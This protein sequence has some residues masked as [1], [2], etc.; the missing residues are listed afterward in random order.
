MAKIGKDV[1]RVEY[2]VDDCT[3]LLCEYFVH[4]YARRTPLSLGTSEGGPDTCS[5]GISPQQIE[6]PACGSP[7]PWFDSNSEVE[8][9]ELLR[10][11]HELYSFAHSLLEECS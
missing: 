1:V 5:M 8:I 9:L 3:Y 11:T 6:L 4:T 7:L 10:N 2:A